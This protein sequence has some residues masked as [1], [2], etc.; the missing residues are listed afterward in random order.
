MENKN[1]ENTFLLDL[2]SKSYYIAIDLYIDLVHLILL[3]ELFSAV[4][5]G[6]KVFIYLAKN[7]FASSTFVCRK[8]IF[9]YSYLSL[10]ICEIIRQLEGCNHH[11]LG[12]SLVYT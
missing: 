1:N 7:D 11:Y 5:C 8:I 12:E 10:L 4:L 6:Y 3:Q 9:K 2:S